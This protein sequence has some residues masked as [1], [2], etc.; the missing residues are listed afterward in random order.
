MGKPSAD[1]VRYDR[2]R[3]QIPRERW[4]APASGL[5]GLRQNGS[6]LGVG[7]D[8][9][10]RGV[11]DFCGAR[12]SGSAGEEFGICHRGI[13][14]GKYR[15]PVFALRR[16]FTISVSRGVAVERLPDGRHGVSCDPVIVKVP[17]CVMTGGVSE[18]AA[19]T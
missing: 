1:T 11:P 5:D 4:S 13:P 8:R 15:T 6:L 18:G 7:N 14:S 16:Y 2:A 17:D 9:G 19:A 3:D 10:R 12:K